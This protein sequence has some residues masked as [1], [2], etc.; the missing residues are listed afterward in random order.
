MIYN[1]KAMSAIV[2]TVILVAL[3]LVAIG[4]VW[5]VLGGMITDQTDDISDSVGCLD[6]TVSVANYNCGEDNCN[7][8]VSRSSGGKGEIDGVRI[9]FSDDSN[10]SAQEETGNIEPGASKTY[11]EIAHDLEG[12]ISDV[13]AG[14]VIGDNECPLA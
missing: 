9:Q 6:A 11:E 13:K 14:A 10:S 7:V 1:K 3:A 5:A 4:I 8:T 12:D 2:T